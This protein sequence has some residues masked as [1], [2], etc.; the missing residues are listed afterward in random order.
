[1]PGEIG[2]EVVVIYAG[3]LRRF[4]CAWPAA[5]GEGNLRVCGGIGQNPR[6]PGTT[7]FDVSLS[8]A[9]KCG[10][11]SLI[12]SLIVAFCRM[13]ARWKRGLRGVPGAC[14]SSL[15]QHAAGGVMVFPWASCNGMLWRN[16]VRLSV[17]KS[18]ALRGNER[19]RKGNGYGKLPEQWPANRP[20]LFPGTHRRAKY[21]S[22]SQHWTSDNRQENEDCLWISQNEN[23]KGQRK[24]F[25]ILLRGL[26]SAIS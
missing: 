9:L 18:F 12:V 10:S 15:K 24:T 25:K 13:S 5:I 11:P 19:T 21:I 6:F 7:G 8:I 4:E 22:I 16:G 23:Q 1:M 2:D 3:Y 17:V 14:P 20:N 26:R